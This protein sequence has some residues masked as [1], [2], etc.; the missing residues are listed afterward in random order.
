MEVFRV[1]VG[2]EVDYP[3]NVMLY[4]LPTSLVEGSRE[5]IRAGSFVTWHGLDR[6]KHLQF[7]ETLSKILKIQRREGHARPIEVTW[8]WRPLSHNRREVGLDQALFS[9]V[10][11]D[12][13]LI[14]GDSLNEVFP[15]NSK[16]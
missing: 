10:V 9:I 6:R 1:K 15:R 5:A 13:S 12:P 8:A 2:E 11:G 4:C 14:V 3:H 16:S 7:R